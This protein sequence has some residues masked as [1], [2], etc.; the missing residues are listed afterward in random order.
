MFSWE[1]SAH[2]HSL[3]SNSFA[4]DNTELLKIAN[5]YDTTI[6]WKVDSCEAVCN[7]WINSVFSLC[8]SKG[9]DL[10]RV[11]AT[12]TPNQFVDVTATWSKGEPLPQPVPVPLVGANL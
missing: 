9:Y 12:I 7:G 5:S 6:M 8:K 11:K 3:D 2:V 10:L 1:I 4:V